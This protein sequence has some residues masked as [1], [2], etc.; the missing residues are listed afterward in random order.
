MADPIQPVE[1][2]SSSGVT[3]GTNLP[4]SQNA[5][6]ASGTR[7]GR[8]TLTDPLGSGG[9]GVVYRA[10]D[11]KLER[12]VAVKVLPSGSFAA[13]A[14]RRF[15]KEALALAKL[16]H[17]HIAAIFDVGEQDGIDYIVM[18]CVPGRSLAEKLASGPLPVKE[19][20]AIALQIAQALEEAQEHG[21][22]HR[23]LKP[24]GHHQRLR[25]PRAP[26]LSRA[27]G[28]RPEPRSHSSG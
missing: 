17:P 23:D 14:R 1:E 18:E 13:D 4:H 15:H 8:Y 16:S 3:S 19:A 12:D 25:S 6:I 20:T 22:V 7:L 10:R 24:A 27:D 5:G 2:I 9:M 28:P 11:E 26:V 21:V